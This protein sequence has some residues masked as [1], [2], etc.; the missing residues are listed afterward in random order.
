M[1]KLLKIY[2]KRLTNLSTSN[3]S[4]LLLRLAEQYF[5]DLHN[6]D[7]VQ[8]QPSFHLITQ[9]LARKKKIPLC[10]VVDSR[11]KNNNKIANTLHKIY[12]TAQ[13]IQEERGAKNLYVGY[14]FVQGKMIDDTLVR[15]PLLFFPVNLAIENKQW[16]L[17]TIENQPII[18]NTTF[19]LAYTHYNQVPLP[20][21]LL[22]YDFEES[23]QDV[24][25]F[26]T[27]L[28]H[29]L[30]NSPI[31]LHFNQEIFTNTLHYFQS[32]TKKDFDLLHQTGKL[33]LMPEAVLGVFPLADSYLMPDYDQLLADSALP[34]LEELLS[35]KLNENLQ[36][37][38]SLQDLE[39][40]S[41]LDLENLKQQEQNLV[42]PYALDA[43]QEQALQAVK[44]GKSAVVQGPPGTGKSQL[45][46]NLIADNLTQGKKVLV[47]CQ[48]RAALDVV[49]QRLAE[50]NFAPFAALVHDIQADRAKI[51][52]QIL[53]H[54]ENLA[55]YQKENESFDTA[56]ASKRFEQLSG[57]IAETALQIT[58]YKQ[59]L[60]DTSVAGISAKELYLTTDF[61]Q[62]FGYVPAIEQHTACF[63]WQHHQQFLQQ[64]GFWGK[65]H[66]QVL[67]YFEQQHADS[68]TGQE[69]AEFWQLRN[70]FAA[71]Q[72]KDLQ[73]L[74]E[75][76]PAVVQKMQNLTQESSQLLHKKLQWNDFFEFA[77][78]LPAIKQLAEKLQTVVD[79]RHFQKVC[80]HTE[81]ELDWLFQ[82]RQQ[83][84]ACFEQPEGIANIPETI[85]PIPS[86]YR[87][88]EDNSTTYPIPSRYRINEENSTTYPIPSRYRINE[89]NSTTYPIPSRY[90][91]NEVSWETWQTIIAT[92]QQAQTKFFDRWHWNLFSKDKKKLKALAAVHHLLFTPDDLALLAKKIQNRQNL[93]DFKNQLVSQQWLLALSVEELA[94]AVDKIDWLENIPQSIDKQDF[95]LWFSC[96][97]KALA[98]KK[99]WLQLQNI[100]GAVPLADYT[101][102][103]FTELLVKLV[104]CL[105]EF[106]TNYAMWLSFLSP[107]QLAILF[108]KKDEA[109][110][111]TKALLPSLRANFATFCEI[112]LL[113]KNWQPVQN[114]LVKEGEK[115][116][117]KH[118]PSL[119][120]LESIKSKNFPSLKDL[121]SIKLKNFPSL[122]DLESIGKY[123]KLVA[124]CAS[125]IRQSWL[126]YLQNH[127]PI[128]RAVSGFKMEQ[129]ENLL[130][131]NVIEKR[132]LSRDIVLQKLRERSYKTLI[133]NR[134][135]NLVTYRD[136]KHQVSKKRH[137]FPLRK[138]L[139]QFETEIFDLLPCWLVSPETASTLFALQPLF[140]LV[141]FDE[142]SQCYAEK[143]IPA[144]YRGKQAVIAGDSQQL[145][146][147]DLYR[148]R[149]EENLDQDEEEH[150]ALEVESLLDLGSR[151]LPVYALREH[152][153]SR[154]NSLIAFSNQIFYNNHLRLIPDSQD[155]ASTTPA[156]DYLKVEGVW[157]K[158]KNEVEAKEVVALLKKLQAEGSTSIGVITFNVHQQN[159]ILD[160]IDESGLAL[161]PEVFVKNIENVQG[162]ERDIIIF[163]VGY[164]P[165][166]SGRWA[167]QFG[168]LNMEKGQNRLNVAITRAKQKIYVVAS[169]LPHQL[170]TENLKNEG[171]K[172]LQHYLHYA[173]TVSQGKENKAL[174]TTQQPTVDWY[175]KEKI[176][177]NLLQNLPQNPDNQA[178]T[179]H[180][181]LPFADLAKGKQLFLTDD[182]L[183][184]ASLSAKE[185]L[186]Y[187]PLQ[188]VEKNWEYVRYWSFR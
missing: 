68:K 102:A 170:Q 72:P 111:L 105:E 157:E 175:L 43:S 4:L 116:F 59:A 138:L 129:W 182:N 132:K 100:F 22:D 97:D 26:H 27:A 90:R 104:A 177:Q 172:L 122:K 106:E 110:W 48:K 56:Y 93:E 135:G 54:I 83:L 60:F 159:L 9:L 15:C 145:A 117:E 143:A 180:E 88:N 155:F 124:Y 168:L 162:D 34:T 141:I 39:S 57:E 53:T 7:F 19:L 120:N 32:H 95:V 69:L 187:L 185:Y 2:Q 16:L 121:E 154:F 80:N 37:F 127:F 55:V 62:P 73:P 169:I 5:L 8:N 161:A 136:L 51:F 166:A 77:K 78:Q 107:A 74:L 29:L 52:Q 33:K 85:Y 70:S 118:F 89:D 40:L 31:D 139:G 134:L 113:E 115:Y 64:V 75:L 23:S 174:P 17:K 10:E 160:T 126:A 140:D 20:T 82:L 49:N 103:S 158:N 46:C 11:D 133:I 188:L 144:L 92:Y 18:W 176:K 101:F 76:L 50:K 114:Q 184:F 165:S 58:Q 38:P 123:E 99:L 6:L 112:D 47:V 61:E 146:P 30:A 108:A 147:F 186:A 152:Y 3:K 128:L 94:V 98:D 179:L 164:A 171:V 65:Y 91:I 42:A 79:F 156:I 12:R 87:I 1:Q 25:V 153:R 66:Q 13:I 151:Y 109:N 24:Q 45:I 36:N 148:P 35:G 163:S 178:E 173:W 28:Y 119:S 71:Y 142:A 81:K 41:S 183:F 125:S 149:W 96:Y 21:D 150:L 181:N 167:M 86:R 137:W 14:P 67:D 44:Q 63:H 84:F 131:K 130:Q